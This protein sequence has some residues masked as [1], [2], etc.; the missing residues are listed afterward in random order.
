MTIL[1]H[2][3]EKHT[4]ALAHELRDG[5][6]SLGFDPWTPP[7]NNSPI[8]SFAHGRKTDEMKKLFDKEGIVVTFREKEGSVIRASV[9]LFNNR[10]DIQEAAEV[11]RDDRLVP[12]QTREDIG[13]GSCRVNWLEEL[14]GAR[15]AC[16][17][18]PP[19]RSPMPDASTSLMSTRCSWTL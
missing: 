5:L 16:P 4:V 14:E 19:K 18:S 13:R 8:V 2:R 3:I 10:A 12:T 9:A 11:A 6:A 7:K 1:L 15:A 17:L